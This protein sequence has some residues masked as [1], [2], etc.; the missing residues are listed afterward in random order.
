MENLANDTRYN[1]VCL[2]F[3]CDCLLRLVVDGIHFFKD[4][5]YSQ[6]ISIQYYR[7]FESAFICIELTAIEMSTTLRCNTYVLYYIHTILYILRALNYVFV[8]HLSIILLIEILTH[9]LN[10]FIRPDYKSLALFLW[11]Y[12]ICLLNI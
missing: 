1:L 2:T 3:S 4:K 6:S 9:T 7:R 10:P 11:K 5:L 12:A 8:T